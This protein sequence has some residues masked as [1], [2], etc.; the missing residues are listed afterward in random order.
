M[1]ESVSLVRRKF[2]RSGALGAVLVAGGCS[3]E[4]GT[5]AVTTPPVENGNRN[6]LKSLAEKAAEKTAKKK[7]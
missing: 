5:K 7:K 4:G 3:D 1:I 6:R 2:L